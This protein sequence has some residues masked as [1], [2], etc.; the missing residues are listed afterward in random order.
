[1][2][3]P[4]PTP[5]RRALYLSRNIPAIR[6]GMEVGEQAVIVMA[7]RFG[8]S[9]PIPAYPSIHIGSADVYP[10]EMI[11]AYSAF[12]NLGVRSTPTAI[13]RVENAKGQVLRTLGISHLGHHRAQLGVY[14]R[15][16]G[17]AVPATYG[18]SADE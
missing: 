17:I 1:M 12:A 14:L 15:L 8:I 2:A 7:K 13:V 11:A 9:T 10:I 3:F 5:M 6:M 16:C 18:P 4:L